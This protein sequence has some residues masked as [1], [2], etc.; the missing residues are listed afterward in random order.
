MSDEQTIQIQK[1]SAALDVSANTIKALEKKVAD[2]QQLFAIH[3]AEKEQWTQQKVM[4]DRI[5]QQQLQAADNE[6]R[7]LEDEII[8]LREQVK[9]LKAA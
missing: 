1:L 8:Q 2:A 5:I 3:E 6:K 7:R 9:A 4:R